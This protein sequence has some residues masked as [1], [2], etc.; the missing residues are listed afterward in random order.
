MSSRGNA[1]PLDVPGAA[2]QPPNARVV[3][4]NMVTPDYFRTLG[5]GVVAG[6]V[7]SAGD[8]APAERVAIVN[9]SLARFFFGDENPIGRSVHYYQDDEHPMR[10][11]GVVEDA[12]QRT[13]REGSLRTIYTPLAQLREPEGLVTMALRIRRSPLGLASSL[14]DEVRAVNRDV[15]VDNIRTM[16]QQIDTTLV[17]ERLVSMLSAAF[18]LLA[19]AMSCLGLYGVVSFDV[20][21]QIRDIG[22]RMALGAQRADVIW[23][24][25]RSALVVSLAGIAAG[26]A[27]TIAA[28]RTLTALL[29][30]IT[31]RDPLTLTAAAT[32]LLLTALAASLLPARRASRVDPMAVLR[33]E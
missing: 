14:R 25:L 16:E 13:I 4:T 26:L 19:L 30:D 9:R 17:R 22:V 15:V 28:T 27:A 11:V 7:F 10:I 2:P 8:S 23:Q 24:V 18:G 20:G 1:R 21:R 33:A 6:R 12:T 3:F 5:I 29:F 31:P 32:L